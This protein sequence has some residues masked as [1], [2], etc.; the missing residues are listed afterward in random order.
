MILPAPCAARAGSAWLAACLLVGLAAC[1]P[2]L[3]WRE[4]RPPGGA[5]VLLMPCRPL[6]QERR[7]TLAGAPVR[8]TLQACSAGGQ[9]W[10]VAEADIADPARIGAALE[11][12]RT[13]MAANVAAAGVTAWPLA[14]P[15]ATPQPAAGGAQVDGRLPDGRAVQLRLAVFAHGTRVYQ[16]TVLGEQVAPDAA[17]TF[18][19]SIRVQP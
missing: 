6:P 14:V 7:L 8:L 13:S 4:V 9:T 3:D 17:Q 2:A 19:G 10:A 1:A 5:V 15:G 12:L 11:E 18:F 16:A